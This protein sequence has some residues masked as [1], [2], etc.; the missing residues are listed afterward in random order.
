MHEDSLLF[1][2]LYGF[3]GDVVDGFG[4]VIKFYFNVLDKV[5]AVNVFRVYIT[6]RSSIIMKLLY[7]LS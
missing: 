5:S 2:N 6:R 4:E 3:L 1:G 7:C